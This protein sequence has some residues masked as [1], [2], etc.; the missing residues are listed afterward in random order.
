MSKPILFVDRDGTLIQEPHDYVVDSYEKL[1]FLPDVIV[2]LREIQAAGWDLVIVTNQDGLGGRY[3]W[4]NFVGPHQLM[5][6]IFASQRVTFKDIFID[7]TYARE[8]KPTR[9]P[10][11]A[12]VDHLRGNQEINWSRSAM[13]GDRLSDAEFGANLGIGAFILSSPDP[14]LDCGTWDWKGICSHLL[15][16]HPIPKM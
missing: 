6:D 12:L 11:T 10:G 9:K 3:P 1:K 4:S 5:L 16:G 14:K 2:A 15:G 7:T 8:N 13:V